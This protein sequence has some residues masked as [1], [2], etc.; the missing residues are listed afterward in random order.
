M[1]ENLQACDGN[2]LT[3]DLKWLESLMKD[4]VCNFVGL[5]AR[6]ISSKGS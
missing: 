3:I 6:E 5:I 1:F 4:R 2:S